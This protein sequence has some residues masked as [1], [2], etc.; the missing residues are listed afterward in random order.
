[1]KLRAV[2]AGVALAIGIGFA[3]AH[4]PPEHRYER[5]KVETIEHPTR[6]PST[7]RMLLRPNDNPSHPYW[8][9]VYADG[10][11]CDAFKEG[12]PYILLI[13]ALKPQ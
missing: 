9:P 6:A 5:G 13:N 4:T 1:M 2:V 8:T 3:V 7:C 10:H 12:G 11:F